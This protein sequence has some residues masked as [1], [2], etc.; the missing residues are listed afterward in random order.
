MGVLN[1]NYTKISQ[2]LP[3]K[4]KYFQLFKKH[5]F[6]S[7]LFVHLIGEMMDYLMIGE[8]RDMLVGID[9]MGMKQVANEIFKN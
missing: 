2:M 4:A 5:G 8:S 3:E 6:N 1:S 7:F 9:K